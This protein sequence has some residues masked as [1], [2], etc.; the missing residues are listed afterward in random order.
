VPWDEQMIE[1]KVT[2]WVQNIENQ[3][4]WD[5]AQQAACLWFKQYVLLDHH[6]AAKIAMIATWRSHVQW[7]V[8]QLQNTTHKQAYRGNLQDSLGGTRAQKSI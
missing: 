1:K 8:V 3:P 6:S 2:S 4:P 7:L 5:S